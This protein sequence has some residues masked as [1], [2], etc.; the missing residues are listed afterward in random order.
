MER[1]RGGRP[2]IRLERL[3]RKAI[4]F[5]SKIFWLDFKSAKWRTIRATRSNRCNKQR[6]LLKEVVLGIN[7]VPWPNLWMNVE[8]RANEHWWVAPS[9]NSV[10]ELMFN[11]LLSQSAAVQKGCKNGTWNQI[12]VTQLLMQTKFK[13]LIHFRYLSAERLEWTSIRREIVIET[14]KFPLCGFCFKIWFSR[15]NCPIWCSGIWCSGIA[16]IVFTW[17]AHETHRTS[18]HHTQESYGLQIYEL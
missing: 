17:S 18:L 11:L 4:C 16:D 6:G 7:S 12:Y 8:P 13:L 10:V 2:R 15:H 3:K 5:E 14:A 9:S 1:L